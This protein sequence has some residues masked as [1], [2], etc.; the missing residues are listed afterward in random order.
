MLDI[1]LP[2]R[3]APF[4]RHHLPVAPFARAGILLPIR[5]APFARAGTI[6]PGT[7]CPRYSSSNSP[8]TIC[9][10]WHHLPSLAVEAACRLAGDRLT[11]ESIQESLKE[12]LWP[13]R[14]QIFRGSVIVDGAHN[15]AA[16]AALAET[17]IEEFGKEEMC[18]LVFGAARG[19][20]VGAILKHLA[21]LATR[22]FWVPIRSE[23]RLSA[24][25]MKRALKEAGFPE[26]PNEAVES[27]ADAMS[28]VR[29]FPERTL[30]TG[31]LFL[32]G[33][34]LALFDEQ[35]YESSSQ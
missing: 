13:G 29:D 4:A 32:A 34:V 21:P 7:I 27:I 3:L 28:Q 11:Q 17:W 1:L 33:E 23:R 35:N 30:V 24:D 18:T 15:E 16:A 5:L 9:P 14:F 12:T 22:I 2:I 20:D 10:R 6:C 8:G 25:E 19:K 26:L 31:S